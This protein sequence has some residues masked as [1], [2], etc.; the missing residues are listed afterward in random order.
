MRRLSILLVTIGLLIALPVTASG[1]GKPA[2]PPSLGKTCAELVTNGALWDLGHPEANG[3]YVAV[4]SNEPDHGG[5]CIDIPAAAAGDWVID[6][7]IELSQGY[8]KG[9]YLLI[10]DSHPGDEC[11]SQEILEPA[12]NGS[13]TATNIP[14]A[15]ENAC[16]VGDIGDWDDPSP[17]LVFIAMSNIKRAQKSDFTITFTVTVPDGI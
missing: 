3:S 10:K 16:P 15:I 1:K 14:A 17:D 5:I 2:R 6:W 9:L 7:E 12:E 11:W 4:I 8:V 13:T